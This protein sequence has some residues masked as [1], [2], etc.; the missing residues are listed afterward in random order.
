MIV[1]FPTIAFSNSRPS[2][3]IPAFH[4]SKNNG[5]TGIA[6]ITRRRPR[7]RGHMRETA[8]RAPRVEKLT[9][10]TKTRN[11]WIDRF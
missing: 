7:G 9:G 6:L 2:N 8:V 10:R 1:R 3:E 4:R 11:R 5:S